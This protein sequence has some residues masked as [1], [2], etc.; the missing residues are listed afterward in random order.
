MRLYDWQK[1]CL[2]IW[3]KN[4]RRGIVHVATGAGKTVLALEAIRGMREQFPD[5]SVKIVVP[6]IPLA[7]QW[8]SALLRYDQSGRQLPGFFGGG[9][10]DDS[11]TQTMIYIINSARIALSAHI[12]KELAQNHHVLLICDECHHYASPQNRRIFDFFSPAI[13]S[14]SL[15]A[16]MG[17][18]ATPF[19]TENDETLVRALGQEIFR[20]SFNDAAREEILSP[21]IVCEV[22]ASFS[23]DELR[24]YSR[25]S[26]EIGVLLKKLYAKYPSLE[27]LGK[28][29]FLRAVSHMAHKAEMDPKDP[30]AAFLLKTYQR[31]EINVLASSRAQCGLGIM[32]RLRPDDRIIV[33]CERISQAESMAA[34]IRRRFGNICALYHSEMT[35]EARD[36]NIQSFRE[37]SVRALVS[38]RCL[39]E[40]IDVPDANIGIV[41]SGSAV[42]RQHIQRLGRLIRRAE[43]KEAAC[44]YHIS[45]KESAE[46][47][48]F[49]PG[50]GQNEKFTLR[51]YPSERDFSNDLYEYVAAGLLDSA[52]AR[53]DNAEALREYR[54]CLAEGLSR[55]DCLLPEKILEKRIKIAKFNHE[56]NYW[57]VM[58][59]VARELALKKKPSPNNPDSQCLITQSLPDIQPAPDAPPLRTIDAREKTCKNSITGV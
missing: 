8:K 17:L 34:M 19:Q 14:G 42:E 23:T 32:E 47:S 30:A 31:K 4:G 44:L 28:Q 15:Y 13:A 57:R 27:R 7:H 29:K 25:L 20:Y 41:L 36:R 59:K 1:K 10:R 2:H 33:F 9:K 18:S 56:R 48:A 58:R 11:D 37:N 24:E 46:D 12:R 55:A 45:I 51:Y 49:L 50:L 40:G 39:D 6:T 43:G 21:F 35:K 5:T 16:C 26:A 53:G 52:K 38:C 22:S 3:E 54:V